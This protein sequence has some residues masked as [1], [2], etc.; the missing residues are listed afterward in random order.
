M[1][2]GGA[3]FRGDPVGIYPPIPLG[4]PPFLDCPN[5]G[6]LEPGKFDFEA[7]VGHRSRPGS[8]G[9]VR[10]RPVKS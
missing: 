3:G 10:G 4:V 8:A 1:P 6:E 5:T 2:L 7:A 9:H